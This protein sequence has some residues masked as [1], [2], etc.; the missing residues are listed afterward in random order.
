MMQTTGARVDRGL[1]QL[2]EKVEKAGQAD[3]T[4]VM[5]S[6]DNGTTHL[7]LEAD[8]EFFESVGELRGLKGSLYEGGV[9]VPTIVRW[10]GGCFASGYHW[11]DGVG[12]NR[13]A[14]PDPVWGVVDPNTFGTDEFVHWCRLIG[15]EPYICTNAGNGTPEEMRRWV[16]YCNLKNGPLAK[17]RGTESAEPLGVRYWSIGN[18]NWGGHEI[19]AKTPAEFDALCPAECTRCAEQD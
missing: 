8:Y 6:S 11:R 1:G 19:G 5:F 18:E 15:A 4:L 7:G 12:P 10:P 17:L 2:L 13:Q 9:R 3:N 14:M 16:E